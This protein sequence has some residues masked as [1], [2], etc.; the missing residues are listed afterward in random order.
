MEEEIGEMEEQKRKAAGREKSGCQEK[1][2]WQEGKAAGRKEKA[3][4]SYARMLSPP[5]DSSRVI[6]RL[7]AFAS[8]HHQI[9]L[10]P[11]LIPAHLCCRPSGQSVNGW[12]RAG[13]G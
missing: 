10:P 2:G 1:S 6:D 11:P 13:V 3:A 8:T 12:R 5:P 4:G 9:P 7:S